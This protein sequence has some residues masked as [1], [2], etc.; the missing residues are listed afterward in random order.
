[1][2]FMFSDDVKV[3]TAIH[4]TIDVCAKTSAI[5]EKISYDRYHNSTELGKLLIILFRFIRLSQKQ[6][7][8]YNF[9]DC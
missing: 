3:W 5:C 9:V 2:H 7:K 8:C 6:L 1:M 4:A